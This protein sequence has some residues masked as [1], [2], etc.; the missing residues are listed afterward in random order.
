MNFSHKIDVVQ[1]IGTT[2]FNNKYFN[3]QKPVIIKGLAD[4]QIAGNKWSINYFRETMGDVQIDVFD[5]G[6]KKNKA[7]AF[8]SPDLKMKLRD[9]LDLITKGE[10]SD[11]RIFLFNLFK[12]NPQLS[13][14][15][16][17]PE[18]MNGLLGNI[19]YMFFGGKGTTVRIHYDIDMSSVMHTHFGGRK[20]IILIPPI[21]STLLYCLPF[22]TYS[23]IDLDKPDFNKYPGLEYI[24]GYECILEHGDS[25]FMPSGYWHY[26]TYLDSSFSVSYRKLAPDFKTKTEGLLNLAVYMP[27]DKL[28]N[29]FLKDK[30][31]Q[32][33]ERVAEERANEI[34]TAYNEV[35]SFVSNNGM[36]L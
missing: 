23:L 31:L 35:A 17:C 36:P 24:N 12:Y 18:I 10:N 8:T 25:L 33:K 5:N 3:P 28:L 21:Y 14:E 9:Y 15:F 7:S 20:K 27:F 34:I 29:M 32:L 6:N 2:E 16:P 11:L 1:N 30:W 19:G 13:K 22:N 4:A 26:M